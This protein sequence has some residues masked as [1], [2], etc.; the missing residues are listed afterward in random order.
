MTPY[1]ARDISKEVHDAETIWDLSELIRRYGSSNGTKGSLL[2]VIHI[3]ALFVKLSKFSCSDK[4]TH[5]LVQ[6]IGKKKVLQDEA[7]GTHYLYPSDTPISSRQ[8]DHA[9]VRALP[10]SASHAL[11]PPSVR[12]LV[13]QLLE[14]IQPLILEFDSQGVAS[15]LH[16]LAKMHQADAPGRGGAGRRRASDV[17]RLPPSYEGCLLLTVCD[18]LLYVSTQL[19]DSCSPQAFSNLVYASAVLG[20]KP[21]RQWLSAFFRHSLLALPNFTPQALSNSIWALAKMVRRLLPEIPHCGWVPCGRWSHHP[22]ASI[23][24]SL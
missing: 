2:N 18:D 6:A 5:S 3:T 11:R 23:H 20:L 10:S 12:S 24:L 17:P 22:L 7:G 1:Q 8:G 14:A 21:Q 13:T 4:Q 16:S 9:D 15:T 19:L